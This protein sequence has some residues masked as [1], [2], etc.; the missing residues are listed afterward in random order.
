MLD[1]IRVNAIRE[2][3]RRGRSIRR[4]VRDVGVSRNT[5][6]RYARLGE[7]SRVHSRPR[8]RCLSEPDRDRLREH[9]AAGLEWRPAVFLAGLEAR[10]ISI[11]PRTLRREVGSLRRELAAAASVPGQCDPAFTAWELSLVRRIAR[12]W[13]SRDPDELES[14]LTE[15][16]IRLQARR[17]E[18]TLWRAFVHKALTRAASNWRR[19]SMRATR[20]LTSLDKPLE[21]SEEQSLADALPA[22]TDPAVDDAV[23]LAAA[24]AELDGDLRTTWDALVAENMNQ[25]A[26]AK[27]LNIHRNTLRL[28]LSRMA[29]VFRGH[30]FRP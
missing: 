12:R 22:P 29:R 15:K 11:S 30:G 14:V 18:I 10:G 2:Q 26:A 16:L 24:R 3:L 23:S 17:P 28:R 7:S 20:L 5:V 13:E 8:A 21:T 25:R 4:I 6:R 27:R 9:L 19:D 1:G